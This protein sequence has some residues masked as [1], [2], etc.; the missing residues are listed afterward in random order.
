MVEPKFIQYIPN[1]LLRD[2]TKGCC[3]PFIGSGFSLNAD[4]PDNEKM[5]MWGDLGEEFRKE[6]PGLKTQ[7]PL[8]AISV[9]EFKYKRPALAEKMKEVLL[10]GKCKPGAC[11]SA[12][13]KLPFNVVCTT[14][15]DC[16]LEDAYNLVDKNVKVVV[17]ETQLAIA[18]DSKTVEVIKL[19]GDITTY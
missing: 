19:H 3:V 8:E 16:L 15:F 9:F 10:T 2:I 6:V 11:H 18:S 14:N 17:D 5:L 13:C 1:P 4:I 12:F 7:S